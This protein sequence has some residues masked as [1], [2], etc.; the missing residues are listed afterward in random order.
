MELTFKRYS[1]G[2]PDLRK[3]ISA[4]KKEQL[5]KLDRIPQIIE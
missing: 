4:I 5:D 3:Q 2:I 1:D